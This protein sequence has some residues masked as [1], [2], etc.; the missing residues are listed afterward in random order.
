MRLEYVIEKNLE[1]ELHWLPL[2]LFCDESLVGTGVETF[3][4]IRLYL[5]QD[6]PRSQGQQGDRTVTRLTWR[7]RGKFV[8]KGIYSIEWQEEW[9]IF[10]LTH[11]DNN[12]DCWLPINFQP[13]HSIRIERMKHPSKPTPPLVYS[14]KINA[15]TAALFQATRSNE[16]KLLSLYKW[17]I[18]Q[19]SYILN[20]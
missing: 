5:D 19:A 16:L 9:Q 1:E 18:S 4:E 3:H 11:N 8:L 2:F 10:T 15:E 7:S 13:L 12:H 14:R 20:L 17:K 6:G